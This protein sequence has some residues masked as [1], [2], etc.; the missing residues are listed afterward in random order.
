MLLITGQMELLPLCT[1][2]MG[3]SLGAAGSICNKYLFWR[4]SVCK[5]HL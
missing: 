5:L 1:L 4:M 2:M 3:L